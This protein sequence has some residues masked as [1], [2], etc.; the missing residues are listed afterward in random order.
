MKQ[1]LYLSALI[2]ILLAV[3]TVAVA[4][5][6]GA[7]AQ[8]T[9]NGG[10][11]RIGSITTDVTGFNPDYSETV[12]IS[13]HGGDG[14]HSHIQFTDSEFFPPQNITKGIRTGSGGTRNYVMGYRPYTPGGDRGTSY[15]YT[16]MGINPNMYCEANEYGPWGIDCK[17]YSAI[18]AS[19]ADPSMLMPVASSTAASDGYGNATAVTLTGGYPS[20]VTASATWTTQKTAPSGAAQLN[21]SSRIE[22]NH[23]HPGEAIGYTTPVNV[24]TNSKLT[25]DIRAWTLGVIVY[26]YN[27]LAKCSISYRDTGKYKLVKSG[28]ST[29]LTGNDPLLGPDCH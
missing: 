11:L 4:A 20:G 21:G 10:T 15:I 25:V 5:R 9:K 18:A 6:L 1:Y 2:G 22:Y 16:A 14:S 28:V 8:M 29:V 24:W 19:T 17:V 13:N 23:H 7:T 3:T 26:K 27:L 12:V